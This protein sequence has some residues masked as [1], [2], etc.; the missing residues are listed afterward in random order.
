MDGELCHGMMDRATVGGIVQFAVAFSMKPATPATCAGVDCAVSV[1]WVKKHKRGSKHIPRHF[2]LASDTTHT[3]GCDIFD[4]MGRTPKRASLKPDVRLRPVDDD[5][6]ERTAPND[7]ERHRLRWAQ[8][9][10][11]FGGP[12]G[13]SGNGADED[14]DAIPRV[15]LRPVRHR[16]GKSVKVVKSAAHILK[17]W[18][19]IKASVD[20]VAE[21]NL[22]SIDIDGVV[23]PWSDFFFAPENLVQLFRRLHID[24][25]V[26]HRVAVIVTRRSSAFIQPIGLY[27]ADCDPVVRRDGREFMLMPRLCGPRA[28]VEAAPMMKA[29]VAVGSVFLNSWEGGSRAFDYVDVT[30]QH[31]TDLAVVA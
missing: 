22:V 12:V 14:S 25:P 28:T 4:Q 23:L 18:E 8:A 24:G 2:R 10:T 29:T 20:P 11:K 30:V 21:A 7:A 15:T 3:S 26:M 6:L 27:R 1:V 9:A 5:L 31:P 17:A 19:H 16:D 13:A